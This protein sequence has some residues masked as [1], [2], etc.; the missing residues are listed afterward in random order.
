MNLRADEE[1]EQDMRRYENDNTLLYAAQGQHV[2]VHVIMSLFEL[3]L[4]FA[5]HRGKNDVAVANAWTI[6]D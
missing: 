1:Y 5:F 6:N 3:E 2:D 4:L